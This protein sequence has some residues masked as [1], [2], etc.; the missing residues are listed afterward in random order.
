MNS[1]IQ[2]IAKITGFNSNEAKIRILNDVT[3]EVPN[4]GNVDVDPGELELNPEDGVPELHK[5]PKLCHFPRVK[6][7]KSQELHK[8]FT[9]IF[10]LLMILML[11]KMGK[12]KN[13]NL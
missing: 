7:P 8:D 4:P 13:Q 12:C 6:S 5:R 1:A 3:G 10:L 11:L 2:D 9:L